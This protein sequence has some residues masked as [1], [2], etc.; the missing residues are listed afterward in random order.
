VERFDL[1]VVGT[2]D[3][4]VLGVFGRLKR[5]VPRSVPK[6]VDVFAAMWAQWSLRSATQVALT[7]RLRGRAIVSN[8]GT[9]RIGDR[10]QLVGTVASLELGCDEG[11]TLEIG[12]RTFINYGTSISA[13]ES[14]RIGQGCL[15]GTHC[16]II[17]NE[18]H[19]LEPHRRLE[20]PASRPVVIE[21]NVWLGARVIVLPGVTIGAGS[22]VGAG[23]VV[24]K[25]IP[26]NCVAAGVPARVIRG[27]SSSEALG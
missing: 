12:S 24:T 5:A 4:K 19:R 8:H 7:T 18:F 21:A 17:D 25:D 20:R 1:A 6:S 3:G 2:S 13:Y 15:I 26:G 11:A 22:A 23:S 14:V 27:L 16:L 9:M 10:V